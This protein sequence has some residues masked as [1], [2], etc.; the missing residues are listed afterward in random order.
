MGTVLFIVLIMLKKRLGVEGIER[1]W[2]YNFIF[3]YFKIPST[4]II[5]EN[6]RLIGYSAFQNCK[7]LEK[8]EIPRFT[9]TISYCAFLDCSKLREIVISEGVVEIGDEAFRNCYNLK[10][11]VIPKSVENIGHQAFWRC[12]NAIVNIERPKSEFKLIGSSAF[13]KCKSVDYAEEETGN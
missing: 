11:V 7:R 1:D 3:N 8:V 10:E 5:P 6:C 4:L 9:K 12:D 13:Y 2:Y